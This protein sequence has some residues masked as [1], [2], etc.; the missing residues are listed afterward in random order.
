MFKD[1][2]TLL[3]VLA[4][5]LWLTFLFLPSVVFSVDFPFEEE[6][7]VFKVDLLQMGLDAKTPE[8]E[9]TLKKQGVDWSDDKY[10]WVGDSTISDP[11]WIDSDLDD[12][13]ENPEPVCFKKGS[14]PKIVGGGKTKFK[15]Q[16]DLGS[17]TVAAKLKIVATATGD[18]GYAEDLEFGP[19]DIA[20]TGNL[21]DVPEIVE[22]NGKT[23]GGKV[24]NFN[25]DMKWSL[26][27][28]GGTTWFDFQDMTQQILVTCDT[29]KDDYCSD[30]ETGWTT[31]PYTWSELSVTA[32]R[33]DW[34]CEA[35][36]YGSDA[37]DLPDTIQ[38]FIYT[39]PGFSS[40]YH[41]N[42]F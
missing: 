26:S 39:N 18:G 13:P 6:F 16:P 9:I 21:V 36:A 38:S 34:A 42:P 8:N 23:V 15:V 25:Y 22:A 1:R 28:D 31:L 3:I 7:T 37:S 35:G 30:I 24:N 41:R 2:P 29:P 33:M 40:N 12:Y 27:L 4:F 17:S 10:A 14:V 19:L 32:K 11:V 5:G 20:L